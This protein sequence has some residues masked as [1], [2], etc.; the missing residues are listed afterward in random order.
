TGR[1]KA[2]AHVE[3]MVGQAKYQGRK[4][5][6][7]YLN[8][9]YWVE[10]ITKRKDGLVVVNNLHDSGKIEVP[11]LSVA[12]EPAYLFPLLRGSD[13]ERWSAKPKY[14]VLVPHDP[15]EPAKA[16]PEKDLQSAAPHTF[17]YLK[18]FE[19][20]LRKRSGFK[21]YFDSTRAPFYSVYN[22]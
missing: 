10:E 4:G 18:R 22:V 7:T 20:Q 14:K 8:G 17:S 5:S 6:C 12:L 9:V 1:R 21:L 3:R 16:V 19:D 15:K 2:L 13:V 11:N